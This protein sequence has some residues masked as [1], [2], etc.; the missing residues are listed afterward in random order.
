MH[1]FKL[2]DGRGGA[3]LTVRVTPRA[4]RTEVAGVRDDGTLKIRVAAPPVEGKANAVLVKFLADFFGVRKRNVEIVA[5]H[6]GLDKIISIQDMTAAD[7]EKR[8]REALGGVD[9]G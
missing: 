2:H 3:A 9:G 5:G 8:I 7:V 6:N 1:K 4:K